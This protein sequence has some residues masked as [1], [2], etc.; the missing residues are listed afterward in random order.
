MIPQHSLASSCTGS[1]QKA[2]E[3]R[4]KSWQD[5]F[6]KLLGQIPSV[7]N[8]DLGPGVPI[9]MLLSQDISVDLC[10]TDQL[11]EFK[12]MVSAGLLT[13]SRKISAT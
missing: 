13:M 6:N 8:Q 11:S 10:S 7:S 4:L 2:A 1:E 12:V 3:V 9:I 5:H